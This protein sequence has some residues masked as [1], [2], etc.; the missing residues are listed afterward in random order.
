MSAPKS[1]F[2]WPSNRTARDCTSREGLF[3]VASQVL[4]WCATTLQ[5][6][7]SRVSWRRITQAHNARCISSLFDSLPM[8]SRVPAGLGVLRNTTWTSHIIQVHPMS[9]RCYCQQPPS[10]TQASDQPLNH[11]NSNAERASARRRNRHDIR[12]RPQQSRISCVPTP[13][14]LGQCYPHP[15]NEE[16]TN[17]SAPDTTARAH[18]RCTQVL[19]C[20]VLLPVSQGERSTTESHII[21]R[22]C[23]MRSPY[24]R[25]RGCVHYPIPKI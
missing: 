5:V 25:Q 10:C 3:C 23:A 7:I 15:C 4:H 19:I 17:I 6:A 18:A 1:Q 20:S 21:A 2:P 11:N 8:A 13:R 22:A 16:R 24:L 14:L 9:S 12:Y